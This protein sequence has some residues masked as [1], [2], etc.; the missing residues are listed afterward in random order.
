MGRA[1][2]GRVISSVVRKWRGPDLLESKQVGGG[3]GGV[4]RFL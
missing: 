2:E 4:N 1:S 3:G